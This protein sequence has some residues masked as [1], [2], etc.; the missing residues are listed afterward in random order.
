MLGEKSS[1][2]L[3]AIDAD[4]TSVRKKATRNRFAC[5]GLG[6]VSDHG[7]VI[8]L[9]TGAGGME[10]GLEKAGYRTAICVEIDA[11]SRAT[12]RKNREAWTLFEDG[13]NRLPGDIRSIKPE[14]LLLKANLKRGEAALVTGGAPCQ[15]FSNMGKKLGKSDPK[16]GDLF[17]EFVRIVLGTQPRG[18]IFE[19]V[20]GIAQ[21]RHAEIVDYMTAQFA[22]SGYNVAFEVLNAADYGVPQQRKR[23]IMLGRRD[24]EPAF[25]L[26]THS[27]SGQLGA[28]FAPQP[29]LNLKEWTSVSDAFDAIPKENFSRFDCIG[30]RHA[31]Y[32]VER[33]ARI[34]QGRNF[35]VLPME[36]RPQCWQSGKHQGQDTF[37]RMEFHKPAP[38]IRTAGYNP[39]KGKYIHP[40]EHRGINT[41]EM[42]ALQSFPPDWEFHTASGKPSIV[43]IG[44]QIGNA[45][46]PNFAAALGQSIFA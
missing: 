25:P 40:I 8:S 46:P 32:M 12:L 42:A 5:V 16:N 7:K 14:E 4:F 38:T 11:D 37:G 39:T 43:S 17:L 20:A 6:R 36:M 33:M 22:G 41:A 35:K 1:A 21:G 19:N 10:I 31:D 29:E 18:F 26:P 34:P 3:Y 45:V 2:R 44:R 15:P 28:E 30:M 13:Q 27:A 24:G 23:F 9:F